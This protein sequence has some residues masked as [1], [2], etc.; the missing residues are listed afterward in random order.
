MDPKIRYRK[1]V[2][3]QPYIADE[4]EEAYGEA[5]QRI[6][7]IDARDGTNEALDAML[8]DIEPDPD[9]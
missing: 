9:Y 6:N 8:D 1:V 4:D 3:V 2:G 7:E 5:W